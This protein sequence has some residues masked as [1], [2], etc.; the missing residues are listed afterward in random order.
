MSACALFSRDARFLS[1][2]NAL[3]M[4][5][6]GAVTLGLLSGCGKSVDAQAPGGAN[7]PMPVPVV[8]VKAEDHELKYEYPAQ[9]S[10]FREVEIRAR[11]AGIIE[12]RLFDEGGRVKKGQSLYRLDNAPYA[13][14][15]DKALADQ[16][17]AQVRAAQAN[18]DL[19]R[20]KPLI[21]SKAVSQAE[22][23]KA[24]SAL[25]VANSDVAVARTQ[26]REARLNLTY[27]QVQ[28]PVGGFVGRS[29]KSEG[30]LVSGPQDLLTTVTQVDQ[31]YANFGMP[32]N[33]HNRLRAGVADGSVRVPPEGLTLQVLGADGKP[34][35]MDAKLA[36]QDVRI[37]PATG[38]VDARALLNNSKETLSP[39]QFV[40][41]LV[42]GAV[43]KN[44]VLLP[45]RAVLES[46]MGGKIVM[47]VA[48]G[49]KV[50]PRPVKVAQWAGEQ[51]L[52]TDGLAAGDLVM[53][54]GFAKAM[55]GT[56]VKPV[57]EQK[58]AQSSKQ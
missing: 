46:P 34:V 1:S 30:S 54:D 19:E 41:V 7:A 50:A 25:A 9:I 51:W 55:P 18:R 24:K 12:K 10:G 38:T 33:D 37:N 56:V 43:Q 20:I 58:Q 23:D 21:E 35:G 52:I 39:G 36:F 11:V 40:R 15:L 3:T 53:V 48:Q 8:Q 4:F 47:T 27:A 42:R 6:M 29:L 45:Q 28:A 14:A 17:A 57:L 31:V 32:E 13:T 26:V 44:A 2:V 16:Q 5:A 49:N 22:F